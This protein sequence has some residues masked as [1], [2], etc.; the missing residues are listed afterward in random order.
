MQIISNLGEQPFGK[1]YLSVFAAMIVHDS[2][3]TD[4]R[5][6]S[7]ANFLWFIKFER[8]YQETEEELFSS[9][10]LNDMAGTGSGIGVSESNSAFVQADTPSTNV[11]HVQF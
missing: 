9:S 8:K 5:D 7:N 10:E 6:R 2:L 1:N 4:V 11:I 3:F